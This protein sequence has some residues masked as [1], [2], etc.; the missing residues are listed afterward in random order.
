MMNRLNFI[1]VAACTVLLMAGC[2]IWGGA[3]AK[4]CLF[5]GTDAK[6]PLWVCGASDARK[7]TAVGTSSSA[8]GVEFAKQIAAMDARK[9]LVVK[10]CGATRT[11]TAGHGY[12][13]STEA[14]GAIMRESKIIEQT[15][16]PDGMLYVEVGIDSGKIDCEVKPVAGSTLAK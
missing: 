2:S 7:V 14:T 16:A 3:L 9:N 11:E 1:V 6:A 5:P 10:L 12:S 13:I 8:G 15:V 4:D